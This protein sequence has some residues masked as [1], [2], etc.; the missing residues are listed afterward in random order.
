MNSFCNKLKQLRG[1]LPV[2]ELAKQKGVA[3]SS[4]YKME[5]TAKVRWATVEKT[6]GHFFRDVHEHC[7]TLILWALAQT[8]QKVALYMAYDTTKTILKEEAEEVSRAAMDIARII[9]GLNPVDRELFVRFALKFRS[10]EP[11]RTM[12]RAWLDAV[13]AG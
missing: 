13:E 8:D 6:Y 10:S 2:E 7:Q 4:I 11:T 1:P 12:I 9:D 5:Q 3:A